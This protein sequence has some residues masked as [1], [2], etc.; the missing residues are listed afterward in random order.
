MSALL[1]AIRY[2]DDPNYRLSGCV[3][4][5]SSSL[6]PRRPRSATLPLRASPA[7]AA[8]G[9]CTHPLPPTAGTASSTR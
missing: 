9:R 4:A 3:L 6:P 1:R 8:T 5:H 2:A 7:D